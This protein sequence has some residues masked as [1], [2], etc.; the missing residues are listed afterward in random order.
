VSWSATS[1]DALDKITP[2]MPPTVKRPINPRAQRSAGLK[3]GRLPWSVA[4]H[5]K[6]LIPVG[7]A[8]I[9]VAAEK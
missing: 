4:I 5:L 2:V 1:S 3:N 8:M 9:I 7:M 6:T